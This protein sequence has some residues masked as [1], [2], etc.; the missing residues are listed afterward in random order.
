MNVLGWGAVLFSIL[1]LTPIFKGEP[2]F[3]LWL[4]ASLF[5]F[6]V[7]VFM[8]L[9]T[10][11]FQIGK[12]EIIH[13]S[14]LG[15]YRIQWNEITFIEYDLYGSIVLNGRDKY[16]TIYNPEW[17]ASKDRI[18]ADFFIFRNSVTQY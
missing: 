14:K 7:G 15:N 5:F 16:L 9:C 17:W 18:A 3:W 4:G 12:E 11:T 1:S 8:I 10:G 13:S 6:G 2:G